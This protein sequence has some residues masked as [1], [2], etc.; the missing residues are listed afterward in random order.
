MTIPTPIWPSCAASCSLIARS[1]ARRLK[2]L[3]AGELIVAIGNPL[4]FE[5]NGHSRR[6]L[7]ARAIFTGPERTAHRQRH[8][9][10]RGTQPWQFRWTARGDNRRSS[11]HQ[12]R[13]DQRS[14]GH[15]LCGCAATRPCSSSPRSLGTDVCARAHRH[16]G[17]DCGPTSAA[18]AGARG[19]PAGR[20]HRRGRAGWAGGI[21]RPAR[22]R[23]ASVAR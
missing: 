3:A 2:K 4:G 12:H 15:L 11:R 8:S 21:G 19:R 5:S 13:D 16:R 6:R 18:G 22:G 23:H 10:R 7:G 9:D 20:A 14:A 17:A 1:R